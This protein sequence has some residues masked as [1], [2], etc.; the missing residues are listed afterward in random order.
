MVENVLKSLQEALTRST[1]KKVPC[2][3]GSN[4]RIPSI[5]NDDD[6]DDYESPEEGS[7]KDSRTSSVPP[8]TS[9]V[10]LVDMLNRYK[11]KF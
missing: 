7:D 5:N 4:G 3:G 2:D 1:G 10:C 6:H 11:I 9:E 8:D